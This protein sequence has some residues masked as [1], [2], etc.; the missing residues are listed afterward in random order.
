MDLSKSAELSV[1]LAKNAFI[2]D[3][4][5][6]IYHGN[7][8]LPG[9][10]EFVSWLKSK[11]KRF[12]L[13]H[14]LQRKIAGR[15]F[16]KTRAPRH[17]GR[18]EA[19]LHER[20]RHRRLP[21]KPATIG[22]GIR[23]WRARPHP[24]HVRSR[25]HDE[26]RKPRLCRRRRGPLLQPRHGGKSRE[27]GSWRS[28]AHRHEPRSHRPRRRRPRPGLRSPCR[29]PSNSPRAAKRTSWESPTP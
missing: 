21:R 25:L 13:P 18:I 6:V 20:P 3:M 12:S 4:D 5:G 24:R 28:E 1:I 19:L 7:R 23:D 10:A 16:P 11:E 14:Q 27:A 2:I 9:A 8:L 22:L 17:R 15:N 29:P 26:Q